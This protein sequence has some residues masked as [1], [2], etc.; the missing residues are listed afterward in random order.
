MPA[1]TTPRD[2]QILSHFDQS[3]EWFTG[4][5]LVNP[6]PGQIAVVGLT[7][8]DNQGDI[9]D[10]QDVQVDPMGKMSAI[11]S[12]DDYFG[13][14]IGSGWLEIQSNVPVL[15]SDVYGNKVNG[16]LAALPSSPEAGT[17]IFP[18]VVVGAPWWTGIAI[19]N[20]TDI[21][22]LLFGTAYSA[23]GEV[24]D[25]ST[26]TVYGREKV[27]QLAQN[28]FDLPPSFVGWIRINSL[29]AQVSGTLVFGNQGTS[30]RRLSALPA[31]ASDSVLHFG[32][33]YSDADWWT[34]IS[35]VNPNDGFATVNLE[36]LDAAGNVQDTRLRWVP[37]RRKITEF[38][39]DLFDLNGVTAGWVRATSD[40]PIV[41]LEVLNAD[42]DAEMAWG[43]AAVP[44][45][46]PSDTV[47]MQHYDSSAI[48]W[49]LFSLV[50]PSNTT[51][52]TPLIRAYSGDGVFAGNATPAIP[53]RGVLLERVRDLF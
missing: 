29:S 30:P 9:I 5:A 39:S 14:D 19:V 38:V 50:N 41:G 47:Y 49:T 32:A 45:L 43:L 46:T 6:N 42:D 4:V 15:A 27:V 36:L 12:S 7:A 26:F 51:P 37:G 8:Y 10:Y 33:F 18:H 53:A 31:M 48:W 1:G 52:A 25:T 17:L 13:S 2:R 35:F 44:V 16:G 23:A 3:A 24:V 21:P 11:L 40:L 28:L 20:A 34:G 22:T